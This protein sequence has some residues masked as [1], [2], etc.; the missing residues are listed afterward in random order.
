MKSSQ[1]AEPDV[2]ASALGIEEIWERIRKKCHTA[3]TIFDPLKLRNY[4]D[5]FSYPRNVN[6]I[7]T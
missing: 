4:L 1:D 3:K 5:S 7:F 2:P 6:K